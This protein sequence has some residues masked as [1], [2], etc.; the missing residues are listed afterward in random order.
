VRPSPASSP[1]AK[2]ERPIKLDLVRSCGA[3]LDSSRAVVTE[4]DAIAEGE[5]PSSETRVTQSLLADPEDPRRA[6]VGRFR[7]TLTRG[8]GAGRNFTSSVERTVIGTQEH[9]DL[10]LEDPTVSRFHCEIVARGDRFVVRD[11]G[12]RNGTTVNGVSVIE[13]HLASGAALR[14]GNAELL[15]E[16]RSD[17]ANIDLAERTRFGRLTGR[18]LAMRRILAQLG[19]AA[20]SDATVLITGETGTGKELAAESIHLESSRRDA[21]FVVVDCASVPN[22][23]LESELFGHEKGAFTGAVSARVGAFE[24]ASGGT[25]FLDEIGEL[26]LELQ[27]K[28][29]RVIERREIKSIGQNRFVPVDVRVIAATNR[30]IRAEVNAKRFRSDLFY[31]LAVIEVEMPPLR[32][33]PEDIP[34]LVEHLVESLGTDPRAVPG[35]ASPAIL[36]ELEG[37]SWPGNVR[38]LRNFVERTVAMGELELPRDAN[39]DAPS[40]LPD[41]DVPLR[42]SRERWTRT[43]EKK[44]VAHLLDAHG[45]NVARAARAAGV[46]RM[47]FYRLLWRHKLR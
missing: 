8:A 2:A 23:L 20:M 42:V 3:L 24:A 45:G 31:R 44:Y 5:G 46:D 10:R 40:A 29:L 30:S 41:F 38:E 4:D 26:Q 14:L 13:A 7:L 34:I 36:R 18:S 16:L 9:V 12:S 28:L 11:L 25:I 27:P 39:L 37:H 21:P 43:L 35:L 15:F 6:T 32:D 1:R 22:E 19:R 17:R 33:R 47:Y